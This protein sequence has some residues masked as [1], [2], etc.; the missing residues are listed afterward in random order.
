QGPE[1]AG[2]G[3]ESELPRPLAGPPR[4]AVLDTGYDHAVRDLHPECHKRLEYDADE[5][6][7]TSDGFLSQE[8][9]HGTFIA[10]IVM[11]HSPQL[12]IRQVRV[13]DPAGMG[14]D[15]TVAR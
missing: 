9:G 1:S 14:D 7:L 15:A 4:I 2:P 12:R 8:A 6:P 11:K 13:L 10:G 3:G 5:S